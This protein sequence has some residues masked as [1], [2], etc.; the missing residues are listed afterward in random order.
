MLIKLDATQEQFKIALVCGHLRN[1]GK[2]ITRPKYLSE[3]I[4]LELQESRDY[5]I[6]SHDFYALENAYNKFDHY[7]GNYSYP[8]ASARS[9]KVHPVEAAMVEFKR[10]AA[11][12]GRSKYADRRRALCLHLANE[13]ENKGMI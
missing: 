5:V 11:K 2:G 9:Y 4:C 10:G 12:W 3:G 13:I 7:S 8:V 6:G 1:L